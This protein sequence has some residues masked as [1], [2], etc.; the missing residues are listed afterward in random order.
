MDKAFLEGLLGTAEG[1]QAVIDAVLAEHEKALA[2]MALEHTLSRVIADAGGRS[3]KAIC[4]LLDTE[5]IRTSDDPKAAAE[6]AVRQLK[7][8][9]DYLFAAPV[10]PAYAPGTG[11]GSFTAP[12][13]QTLAGALK[14][15][16][17]R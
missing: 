7:A 4:A 12:E 5:A 1:T 9:Q 11:T 15:K 3:Q 8:E 6:A 10:P 13:P 2:A 17:R 16:F 14:E